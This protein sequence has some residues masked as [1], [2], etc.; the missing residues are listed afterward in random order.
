MG[1]RRLCNKAK[2]LF[3]ARMNM[4]LFH[5]PSTHIAEGFSI[6]RGFGSAACNPSIGPPVGELL[7]KGSLDVCWLPLE[8]DCTKT[9]LLVLYGA[10]IPRQDTSIWRL[11]YLED[12]EGCSLDNVIIL[13]VGFVGGGF[14]VVRVGHDYSSGQGDQPSQS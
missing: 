10:Y 12:R 4:R 6:G 9:D 11:P 1:S 14:V 8:C 5:C 7:Q 13:V 3:H 2:V